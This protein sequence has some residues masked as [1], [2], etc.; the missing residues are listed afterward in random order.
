[1]LSPS[2]DLLFLNQVNYNT[3]NL[4]LHFLKGHFER[5]DIFPGT[6]FVYFHYNAFVHEGVPVIRRHFHGH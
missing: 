6:K 5:K 2:A 4:Q 3:E 1:M